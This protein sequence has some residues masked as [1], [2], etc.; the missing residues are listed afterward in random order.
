MYI[1]YKYCTKTLEASAHEKFPGQ[2]NKQ[3][4]NGCCQFLM[5]SSQKL[6]KIIFP[7]KFVE[8]LKLLNGQDGCCQQF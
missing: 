2:S 7:N 8:T 3:K 5:E 6:I 4:K 1:I